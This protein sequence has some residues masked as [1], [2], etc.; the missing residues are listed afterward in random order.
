[1]NRLIALATLVVIGLVLF[2]VPRCAGGAEQD[3]EPT[4][5]GWRKTPERPSQWFKEL[6]ESPGDIRLTAER[7]RGKVIFIL[8]K[9]C[10][11]DKQFISLSWY[12]GERSANGRGCN[13]RYLYSTDTLFWEKRGGELPEALREELKNPNPQKRTKKS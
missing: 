13:E 11:K 4:A 7:N 12:K 1:M 9:R 6:G 3:L 2:G 8:M 5:H 10:E